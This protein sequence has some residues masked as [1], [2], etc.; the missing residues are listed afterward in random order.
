[1]IMYQDTHSM[2]C[3]PDGDTDFFDISAGVLQ[4]DTLAPYI[5]II[6]LDYVLRKALDMNNELGFTLTKQKSK[7]YPAMKITDAGYADDLAVLADILKDAT[8]LLHSIERTAKEIG[9]YLNADKTEFICFNQDASER[10]KSLDGEKIKQ[11]EDFKY[12]G[13]YI[14][15]TEHDVNIRLG[16]A[17]NALNELDKI[18]KSNLTDKLKR[19]FFRAAVETVLLYGSVSWTLTTHLEK[20]IDGAYT[21]M[22]RTA[23][24]R[25]W[26]D[27][28]TNVELYGHIPPISK[29]LQQQRMRFAGHCWRSKEEQAGDGLLWKPPQGHQ[30]RGRPKKDLH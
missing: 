10:M 25:S 4:G 15:S 9:F 26:K 13:S 19:N 23:L 21:R 24:N 8:F 12:L 5:F 30:P 11:V 1:M 17:W 16:K 2:V 29:L 27:H 28:P 22:L 6:C 14:A 20:K 7:C 3:S 18:W